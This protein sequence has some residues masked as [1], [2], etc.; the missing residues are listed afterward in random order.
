[1][2]KLTVVP[3]HGLAITSTYSNLCSLLVE[4]IKVEFK[5]IDLEI[6]KRDSI[7]LII[8][9]CELIDVAVHE[10]LVNK[11]TFKKINKN[12][13]VLDVLQV[14]YPSLQ[15]DELTKMRTV[16]EFCID[17][18]LVGQKKGLLRS[19]VKGCKQVY[20]YLK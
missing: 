19:L 3:K 2:D 20:E 12:Q 11:K 6:V 18:K 4:R 8:F 13:L 15:D 9:I 7:N 14:L 10:K 16:L 17:A 1:M 5:N